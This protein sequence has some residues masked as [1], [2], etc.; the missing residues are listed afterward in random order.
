MQEHCCQESGGA[1]TLAGCPDPR[2]VEVLDEGMAQTMQ[3]QKQHLCCR[4]SP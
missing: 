4:S 2:G 3:H 1:E